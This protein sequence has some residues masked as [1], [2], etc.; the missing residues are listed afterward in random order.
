MKLQVYET[1]YPNGP[2]IN[3]KKVMC[4]D[5]DLILD[6]FGGFLSAFISAYTGSV[7]A[8]G[9]SM[10]STANVSK[11]NYVWYTS[12]SNEFNRAT[13]SQN[14]WLVGVGNPVSPTAPAR[15]NY[16]L[17]TQVGSWTP[18]SGNSTWT[19]GTGQIT[20]AGSVL[21]A[22]GATVTEAGA[23][24]QMELGDYSG[25]GYGQYLMFHDTFSGVVIAAGKY[26][27]VAYTL[28]L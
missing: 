10:N 27:H 28:Q 12:N 9:Y 22:A 19:T 21:L 2:P 24:C 20:F 23:V 13:Q 6:N 18:L 1:D 5:N 8:V 17:Q 15:P 14:G 3:P 4:K 11:T 16:N 7:L 25:A 26:A